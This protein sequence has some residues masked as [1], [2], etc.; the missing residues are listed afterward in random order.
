MSVSLRVAVCIPLFD[1]TKTQCSQ[2]WS[3]LTE[4][5]S[6]LDQIGRNDII[7]YWLYEDCTVLIDPENEP[8]PRC[9]LYK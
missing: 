1:S 3:A 5:G 6:H 2:S 4:A 8:L 7:V 9:R